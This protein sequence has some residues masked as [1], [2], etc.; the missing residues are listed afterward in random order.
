MAVVA[1]DKKIAALVVHGMGDQD[2]EFAKKF[3]AHVLKVVDDLGWQSERIAMVPL[4]WANVTQ[5]RQDEYYRAARDTKTLKWKAVRKFVV[6]GFGDATAYQRVIGGGTFE[7]IHERVRATMSELYDDIGQQ[8]LP[9]VV[10]AHSLGGHI[11]SRY[12]KGLQGDDILLGSLPSSSFE[13]FRTH[14]GMLTF[15][16]N[17]PLFTFAYDVVQ[18]IEFPGAD[19]DERVRRRA[20]WR[21]YYDKSDVLGWPLKPLSRGYMHVV[22]A[23]IALKIGGGPWSHSKYWGDDDFIDAVADYLRT[24]LIAAGVQ[25]VRPAKTVAQLKAARAADRRRRQA[26]ARARAKNAPATRREA[27][28]ARARRDTTKKSKAQ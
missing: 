20:K 18:P 11:M 15:G 26:V 23:D 14:A 1:Q 8:E 13:R 12:I 6:N 19:L 24:I 25:P 4:Y 21:N 7:K 3:T 22:D 27:A 9:L 17:I 28:K 5:P 10:I 16:C 2:P